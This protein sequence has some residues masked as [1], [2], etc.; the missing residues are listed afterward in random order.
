MR[1]RKALISAAEIPS[2]LIAETSGLVGFPGKEGV[3]G[4][5]VIEGYGNAL[6][7]PSVSGLSLEGGWNEDHTATGTSHLYLSST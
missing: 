5:E 7:E 6:D 3:L 2:L 1:P 4:L